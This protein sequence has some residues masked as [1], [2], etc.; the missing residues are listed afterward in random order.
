VGRLAA[1][2]VAFGHGLQRLAQRLGRP[3]LGGD[4]FPVAAG[5]DRHNWQP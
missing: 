1:S 2:D 5:G 4:G 3:R